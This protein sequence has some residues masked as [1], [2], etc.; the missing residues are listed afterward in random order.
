MLPLT[1][2]LALLTLEAVQASEGFHPI[3]NP[4]LRV[5]SSQVRKRRRH[6]SPQRLHHFG[7][8]LIKPHRQHRKFP[9]KRKRVFLQPHSGIYYRRYIH[10]F[11]SLKNSHHRHRESYPHRYPVRRKTRIRP[12]RVTVNPEADRTPQRLYLNAV[13]DLKPIPT[14]PAEFVGPDGKYDPQGVAK[15]ITLKMQQNPELAP[16]LQT[17]EVKQRDSHIILKGQVPNQTLL[18]KIIS[19]SR[20]TRGLQ[21]L[22]TQHVIVLDPNESPLE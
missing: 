8:H 12:G 18:N 17:L 1:T 5:H 13:P 11:P 9:F 4:S 2:L 15:Q 3:A 10:P 16:L 19:I 7:P 20:A 21:K 6:F 14:L 22:E